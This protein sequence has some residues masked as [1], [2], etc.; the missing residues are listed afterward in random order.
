M[1][2]LIEKSA[3]SI[4]STPQLSAAEMEQTKEMSILEHLAEL[5]IRL[6][7]SALAI[8]IG[9]CIAYLFIGN[10]FA[11]LSAP[12]DEAFGGAR[13]I[14]TAPAEAF[15]I[16]LKLAIFAGAVLASPVIFHQ[17]WLFVA[18]GLHIHEKKLVIPFIFFT[19]AL[20][21][22]GITF[23]YYVVF[24]FVYKF[25]FDEYGS[26]GVAPAIKIGDHLEFI[27][28]VLLA[29]G[30]MFELPILAYFL[31]KVGLINHR[32]M[33]S[34]GRYAVIIIVV[35]A[36]I[37]TPPDVVT[38]ILM[39]VPMLLLYAISIFVVKYTEKDKVEQ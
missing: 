32:M 29:F 12:Y 23:A 15:V 19:T 39:A 35:V 26:I 30:A 18:P 7:I 27:V 6:F 11:F 24:P 10:I 25:F 21:V 28:Q 3:D 34:G 9:T 4:P 8:L 38:Q 36:A 2:S 5:R 16:K 14:G 33:I 22:M 37:L 20:F 17:I 13:L 31:G 1:T